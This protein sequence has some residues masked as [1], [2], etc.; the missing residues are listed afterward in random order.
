MSRN[1]G[2]TVLA[3]VLGLAVLSGCRREGAPDRAANGTATP[4]VAATGTVA[5]AADAPVALED[6]MERDPRY[7]V[8]ISYPQAAKAYPGLARLLKGYADAAHAE[9]MQAVSGLGDSRP[10][11]PYDLSLDFSMVMETPDVVAVAAHGSTYTGGAHGNPLVARFVWLPKRNEAL[12]AARLVPD[13]DGWK[14]IADYVRDQLVAGLSTRV[15][16]AAQAPADRAEMLRNGSR[17]IDE[18]TAPTASNFDQ[19]EPVAGAGGRI[20]ALRFV[21]APY[22]VGPYSDGVQSVEV[23]AAVLLPVVAPDDRTLFEVG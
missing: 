20:R 22:Q 23:P 12:T 14:P 6:V 7:L 1:S 2:W 13:P 9:L 15:D 11:A 4:G 18:G 19:F 21:F 3:L 5:P 8:G 10:T 16:A 17:M